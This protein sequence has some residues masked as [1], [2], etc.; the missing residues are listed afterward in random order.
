LAVELV[1]S[2][3]CGFVV[4]FGDAAAARDAVVRLAGDRDLRIKMGT[5]G[6][7]A[8]LRSHAWPAR[9][10]SFVSRLEQWAASADRQ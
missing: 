5:R 9:A 6:H 4:P 10:R 7:E 3:D 2:A 1:E 8:A